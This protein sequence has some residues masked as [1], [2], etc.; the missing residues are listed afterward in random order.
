MT[1]WRGYQ[2]APEYDAAMLTCH[3]PGALLVAAALVSTTAAAQSPRESFSVDEAKSAI[4]DDLPDPK[5]AKFRQLFLS[6]H[7]DSKV[8][9]CGEINAKDRAGKYT[10]FRRFMVDD[11]NETL[12]D[13][14]DTAAGA[15]RQSIFDRVYRQACSNKFKDVK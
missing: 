15:W 12:R 3:L 2:D 11:L 13:P 1:A 14:M 10:G 9:L 6:E 5:G 7:G 4:L 8:T